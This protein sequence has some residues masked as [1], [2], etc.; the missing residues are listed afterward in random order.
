MKSCGT[1]GGAHHDL[2]AANLG[3]LRQ[4][5]T[6]PRPQELLQQRTI[7]ARQIHGGVETTG[8]EVHNV[9]G[10]S[11]D[12]PCFLAV[13]RR[14]DDGKSGAGFDRDA[15]ETV[16]EYRDGLAHLREPSATENR[17][18]RYTSRC[19]VMSR[20]VIQFRKFARFDP[21]GTPL[22]DRALAERIRTI[23][24]HP[25]WQEALPMDQR[26][27]LPG[28]PNLRAMS[29]T[30]ARVLQEV[31]AWVGYFCD[32]SASI[33]CS[34]SSAGISGANANLEATLARGGLF[35]ALLS[36]FRT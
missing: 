12:R 10:S 23:T 15:N 3:G 4:S 27:V 31:S 11:G 21:R 14:G 28:Y 25:A 32:G 30:R 26:I 5:G 35:V 18:K 36:R 29:R 34:T 17:R 7:Q 19:F 22:D 16:F 6:I 2:A 33:G 1:E 9:W 24:H 20:A 8:I 13:S